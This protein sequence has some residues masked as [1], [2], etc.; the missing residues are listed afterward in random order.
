M[1]LQPKIIPTIALAASAVFLAALAEAGSEKGD[2]SAGRSAFEKRCTGCHALDHEKT[3]PRLAG[4]VGRKAGSISAFPYSDAVKKS[5]VVWNEA[6]LDK[7]LTDPEAAIPDNDM[8][9]RLDK[10][11]ERANIIEFLKETGK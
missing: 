3:G 2:A 9:F 6:M 8:T 11:I 10:P 1:S 7:W 4:V 5:G